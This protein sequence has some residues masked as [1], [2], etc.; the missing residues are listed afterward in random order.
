M[1]SRL[2]QAFIM[3][4]NMA[5]TSLRVLLTKTT[6]ITGGTIV[7]NGGNFDRYMYTINHG[8]S[9]PMTSGYL[10]APT[11]QQQHLQHLPIQSYQPWTTSNL[12]GL[13][14]CHSNPSLRYKYHFYL[15]VPSLL[16]WLWRMHVSNYS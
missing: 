8:H 16:L 6:L 4:N 13:K 12:S 5:S 15:N 3:T 2:R 11:I 1:F 9:N 7:G 10:P 14:T